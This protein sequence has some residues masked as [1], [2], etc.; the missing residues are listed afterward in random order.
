MKHLIN[1]SVYQPEY[2]TMDR[3]LLFINRLDSHINMFLN[4]ITYRWNMQ[5]GTND[6]LY[7]FII[8]KRYY[9]YL[10]N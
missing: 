2:K 3:K 9:I 10:H 4:N 1:K 5:M 6:N 7:T 8:K